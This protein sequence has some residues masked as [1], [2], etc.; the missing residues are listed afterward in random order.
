MTPKLKKKSDLCDNINK[1]ISNASVKW[2]DFLRKQPALSESWIKKYEN[3]TKDWVPKIYGDEP[4][5][6][7]LA[8]L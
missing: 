7:I 2:F 6:I 8:N 1:A 4:I 3:D 5:F